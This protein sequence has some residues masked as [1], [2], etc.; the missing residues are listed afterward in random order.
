MNKK[1][2]IVVVFFD[3]EILLLKLLMISI[4]KFFPSEMLG[5]IIVINNSPDAVGGWALFD[6]LVKPS[7][8]KYSERLV[9]ATQESLALTVDSSATGYTLQQAMK[10]QASSLVS[11]EEYL[12]FDAKNHLIRPVTEDDFYT[13][14]GKIRIEDC[15]HG[16]YLKVC[17]NRSFDFYGLPQDEDGN[18]YQTVT[19]YMMK[20]EVACE[21]LAEI[22]STRGKNIAQIIHE[23]DKRTE[24]FLYY[25]YMVKKGIRDQHY[26]KSRR[27]YC[28]LFA[29]YPEGQEMTTHVISRARNP[30]VHTFSVHKRRFEQLSEIDISDVVDIWTGSGLLSQSEGE[31]FIAKQVAINSGKDIFSILGVKRPELAG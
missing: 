31:D 14:T 19:P 15:Y 18:A 23:D 29:R 30:E 10:L 11:T 26:A 6:H 2:D 20:T 25:A 1:V 28:T 21:M 5:K 7:I 17:L 3:Q 16:G 22:E 4:E 24:F 8:V 9:F 13:D 12:I 27:A